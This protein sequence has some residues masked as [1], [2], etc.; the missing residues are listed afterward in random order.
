M[1]S[2]RIKFVVLISLLVCCEFAGRVVCSFSFS[3]VAQGKDP[4]HTHAITGYLTIILRA[5]VGY[6]MIDML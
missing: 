4:R 5:R 1:Y 6:G 3:L 2:K